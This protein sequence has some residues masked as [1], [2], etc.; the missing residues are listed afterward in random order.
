MKKDR[1]CETVNAI[2]ITI[3]RKHETVFKTHH[4]N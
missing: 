4:R 3:N 2:K 1:S